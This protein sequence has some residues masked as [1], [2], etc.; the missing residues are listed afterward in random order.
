VT[1]QILLARKPSLLD[2]WKSYT[3]DARALAR[4]ARVEV[5][6][7]ESMLVCQKVK[8][9]DAK[10]VLETLSD[11]YRKE[12]TFETVYVPL[13]DEKRGSINS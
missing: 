7:I 13:V 11:I 12:Y 9:K 2:L 4:V 10:K 1:D 8:R 3:F 5:D 6:I